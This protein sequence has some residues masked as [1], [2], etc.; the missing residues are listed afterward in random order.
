MMSVF[1]FLE[2][3]VI[4]TAKFNV[5]SF[6]VGRPVAPQGRKLLDHN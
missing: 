6:T 4:I 1:R 2:A 5:K 3:H